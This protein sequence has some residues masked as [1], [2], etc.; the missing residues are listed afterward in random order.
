MTKPT[1][2]QN[3]RSALMTP[4]S[5]QKEAYGRFFHTLSAACFIGSVT[6][7]YVNSVSANTV[8]IVAALIVLGLV[9]FLNGA[10]FSKGE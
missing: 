1:V 3:I 4:T 2:L 9:I 5:K 6:T 10:I 8:E 7:G